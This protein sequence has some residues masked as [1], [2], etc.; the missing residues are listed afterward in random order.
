MPLGDLLIIVFGAVIVLATLIDVSLT[1]LHT[2]INGPIGTFVHQ[3]IWRFNVWLSRRVPR[4]RRHL[5]ALSGPIMMMSM[6][7]F[8]ATLYIIGFAFIV[9]PNLGLYRTASGQEAS[10][11]ADAL[12]YSGVT[13]TVLGYGD[14]TP[15]TG[16][17]KILAFIESALGFGL[18]SG[19]VT[20]LVNV[21][22]GVSNRNALA[23]RA[24]QETQGTS[25]GVRVIEKCLP[26]EQ[27]AQIHTRLNSLTETLQQ[28]Q[29]KMRQYP[30]VDLH[31]RSLDASLSPELMVRSLAQAAIGAHVLAEQMEYRS[32][33]QAASDLDQAVTEL[34]QLIAHQH[35]SAAI[36]E[37]LA[38]AKPQTEDRVEIQAI[39]ARLL[40]DQPQADGEPPKAALELACRL[41]I[42]LNAMNMYSGWRMDTM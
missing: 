7:A 39:R 20:W 35:M 12:Y 38:Q 5:M 16:F 9:W 30:V 40:G 18:F 21:S 29:P 13:A 34:M 19:I 26:D 10:G 31:Y 32:L 23:L 6:F 41:R 22:G 42:W 14:I 27:P 4:L 2:D 11:F 17:L 1:V 15:I 3:Q 36:K 28:L 33:R 25:D 8:W 37:E 24:R